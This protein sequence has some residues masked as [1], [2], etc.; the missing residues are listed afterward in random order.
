VPDHIAG[1]R[2]GLTAIA[3]LLALSL[4]TACRDVKIDFGDADAISGSGVAV[5]KQYDFADF[6]Q[7]EISHAFDMEIARSDEFSITV[8]V[9]DNFL[10]HL[11]VE[12]QGG[13]LRI[14]LESGISTRG[15]VTLE[16]RITVPE[17]RRASLSGASRADLSG[18]SS[19]GDVDLVASGASSFSGQLTA[20]AVDIELSGASRVTLTGSARQVRV[21]CSGAS[22]AALE[23]FAVERASVQLS[24]AS[25]ADLLVSDT[26][27]GADLSG[28]SMLVYRGRPAVGDIET[29]GGSR[30]E[31]K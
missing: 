19:S 24:G 27:T 16:A 21:A 10:E 25:R 12:K 8:T 14:G 30:I 9:D 3:A 5:T 22:N 13:A 15:D 7:L 31:S 23:D 6:D 20:E 1:R 2:V 17:L 29:S 11:V 26:L 18:F 4:A 28:A